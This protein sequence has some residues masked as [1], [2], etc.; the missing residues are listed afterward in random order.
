MHRIT[1][2]PYW[3]RAG[4]NMIS[5]IFKHTRTELA[6]SAIDDVTKT[7]PKHT[8]SMESFWLAETIKYAWLLFEDEDAWSLDEWVFNTEAHPLRRTGL[9]EVV[10]KGEKIGKGKKVKDEEEEEE[11]D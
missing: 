7:T 3:R 6:H 11:E 2:S 10:G 1:G 8:D 9:E 5:S 4:W